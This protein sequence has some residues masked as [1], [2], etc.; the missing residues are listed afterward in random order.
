M[1]LYFAQWIQSLSQNPKHRNNK[2]SV[3]YNDESGTKCVYEFHFHHAAGH[4]VA[5]TPR[6]VL[7]ACCRELCG[8]RVIWWTGSDI[9]WTLSDIWW[10]EEDT[11]V[12]EWYSG[13]QCIECDLIATSYMTGTL[14]RYNYAHY[15]RWSG[16][17]TGIHTTISLSP[18]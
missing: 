6:H 18:P 4:A 9:W 8:L 2:R 1:S 3:E 12:C 15:A 7:S 10:T 5:R 17:I 11:A 13:L 14:N 16:R